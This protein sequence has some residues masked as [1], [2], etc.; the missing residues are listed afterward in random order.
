MPES[1]IPLTED[2]LGLNN[3]ETQA[4][5]EAHLRD[6]QADRLP[7]ILK[8]VVMQV[9]GAV[10]SCRSNQLSPDPDLIPES[11]TYYAG[12]IARYRLMSS[13]PGGVSTPRQ[14]EYKEAI[15]WLR[16]VAACRFLIE[17][18]GESDDTPAPIKAGPRI[19]RPTLTQR[20]EDAQ[21]S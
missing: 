9:R 19:T 16:D 2:H 12:A 14:E 15:A 5:R 3:A 11:A 1:W 17:S 13:F 18:P 20:R 6:N 4:Y 10:R 21:G 8:Q 7:D